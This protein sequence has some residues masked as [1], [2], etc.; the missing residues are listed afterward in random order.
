MSCN[1]AI[2]RQRKICKMRVICRFG[3]CFVFLSFYYV[4]RI[5]NK[6][7]STNYRYK[8]IDVATKNNTN[9]Y[10]PK[11][12]RKAKKNVQIN[13]WTKSHTL[14]YNSDVHAIHMIYVYAFWTCSWSLFKC[15]ILFKSYLGFWFRCHIRTSD[16]CRTL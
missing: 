14:T 3:L 9:N 11:R 7:C 5:S 10:G 8:S 16:F 2:H 13:I 15:V 6:Y 12:C 1:F 4:P